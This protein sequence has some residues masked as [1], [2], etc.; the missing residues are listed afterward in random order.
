M[1]KLLC[2]FAV[3]GVCAATTAASAS[4]ASRADANAGDALIQQ[5]QANGDHPS[6]PG[7]HFKLGFSQDPRKHKTFWV[8]CDSWLGGGSGDGGGSGVSAVSGDGVGSGDSSSGV[9]PA[10]VGTTGVP[11]AVVRTAISSTRATKR[12]HHRHTRARPA[13]HRPTHRHAVRAHRRHLPAFSG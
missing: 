3:T 13:R 6:A 11:L 5:V 1:G 7:C 10:P 9:I 12:R 2:V 8:S 4:A